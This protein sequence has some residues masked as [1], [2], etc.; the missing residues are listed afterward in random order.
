M[1][2]DKNDILMYI[3]IKNNKYYDYEQWQ[4]MSLGRRHW[5]NILLLLIFIYFSQYHS[6]VNKQTNHN[7]KFA[8][9]SNRVNNDFLKIK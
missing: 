1:E 8:L 2:C 7:Y 4:G 9:V 3:I 6:T 5:K